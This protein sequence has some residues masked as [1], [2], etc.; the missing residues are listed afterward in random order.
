VPE[1]KRTTSWK[2]FIKAHWGEIFGADFFTVQVLTLGGLVRYFVFFV[3]DIETRRVEIAGIT[4]APSGKWTQQIARNLTDPEDGFLQ[5]VRY[6][7]LDRDPLYTEAFRKM[8]KDCGTEALKLPARSPNLNSYAERFVLLAKSECLDRIVLLSERTSPPRNVSVRQSLSR[9]R[10]P[11]RAWRQP[12]HRERQ[13]RAAR[14]RCAMSRA[15]RRDVE[16]LLPGRGLTEVSGVVGNFAPANAGSPRCGCDLGMNRIRACRTR[17]RPLV[18]WLPT[19]SSALGRRSHGPSAL[20]Q[21]RKPR[22]PSFGTGRDAIR[23]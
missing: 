5:G 2:T 17:P 6:L 14:G 1:R 23:P 15:A 13:H 16:I 19:R 20:L 18:R 8:L 21:S 10:P 3:I 22:Q 9:R 12:D 11:L 7:I 4:N